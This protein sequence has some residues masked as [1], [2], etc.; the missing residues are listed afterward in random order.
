MKRFLFSI[1]ALVAVLM[2]VGMVGDMYLHIEHGYV[3]YQKKLAE[4]D[5][6]IMELSDSIDRLNFR[7]EYLQISLDELRKISSA[8]V[9]DVIWCLQ[10]DFSR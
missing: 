5:S 2:I 9:D 7:V 8:R 3:R 10:D 1:L 6:I 4:K